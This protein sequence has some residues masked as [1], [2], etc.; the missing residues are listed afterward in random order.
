M[1][2]EDK[3]KEV[4]G[5]RMAIVLLNT[6]TPA[7]ICMKSI[8]WALEAIVENPQNKHKNMLSRWKLGCVAVLKHSQS[9]FCLF[10]MGH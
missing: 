2:K 8:D 7:Q 5:K 4:E 9:K 10:N 3:N 1:V 6:A